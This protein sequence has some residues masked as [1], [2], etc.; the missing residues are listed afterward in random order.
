M[1]RIPTEA[2]MV[3]K[4]KIFEVWQWEQKM[5]DGTTT[6]FERLRRPNTAIIIATVGDRILI[7]SERQPDQQYASLSIPGGRCNEGEDGLASAQREL[8]EETG[9]TTNDWEL[10]QEESPV[11][12]IDWTIY[13]YIARGC[14][15]TQEPHL[16]AGEKIT[17]TLFTFEEF[18]ALADDPA[19]NETTLRLM[20]L[21]AKFDLDYR[22][23]LHKQLFE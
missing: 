14:T 17:T 11:N 5:F 23:Q 9:Y 16:D 13:T 2:T 18:L 22:N 15:K 1:Q 7:S 10:L 3:F 21:R 20:L 8:L 6:T 19:F 12:K 4:G